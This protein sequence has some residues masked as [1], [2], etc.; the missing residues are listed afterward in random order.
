MEKSISSF[1]ELSAM[2]IGESLGDRRVLNQ[3]LNGGFEN[4]FLPETKRED[5]S[6]ASSVA[7]HHTP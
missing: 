5:G 4:N 3:I 2:T 7:R 1:T 6:H